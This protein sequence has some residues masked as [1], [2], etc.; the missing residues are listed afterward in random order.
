M[1]NE[2][3][4]IMYLS[5]VDQ[6]GHQMF[7]F[8]NEEMAFDWQRGVR[9]LKAS[10]ANINA[11]HATIGRIRVWMVA[12]Q[13]WVREYNDFYETYAPQIPPDVV[14]AKEDIGRGLIAAGY[15]VP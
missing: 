5:D 7:T 10:I 13:G 11:A 14:R 9:A 15:T 1:A 6:D 2:Q 12:L 8:Y 4:T 3:Y